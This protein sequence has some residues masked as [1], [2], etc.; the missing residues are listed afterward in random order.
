[1]GVCL[2]FSRRAMFNREAE[3]FRYI[4]INV[5]ICCVK[6]GDLDI[7]NILRLFCGKH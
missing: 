2:L 7:L 5:N 3:L 4:I 6:S 1:M